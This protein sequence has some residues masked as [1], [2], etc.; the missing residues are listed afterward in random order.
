M[1]VVLVVPQAT[2][3]MLLPLVMIKLLLK[4]EMEG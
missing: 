1:A 2:V 3:A 4:M